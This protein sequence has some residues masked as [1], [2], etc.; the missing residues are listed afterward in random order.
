MIRT[1]YNL[2]FL[3]SFILF[4]CLISIQHGSWA[5][6]ASL[7]F[8]SLYALLIALT[9]IAV[10]CYGR[11]KQYKRL[12]FF[13][14]ILYIFALPVSL[15]TLNLLLFQ[16]LAMGSFGLW[17]VFLV[18]FNSLFSDMAKGSKKTLVM[19]VIWATLTFLV[20]Y[21]IYKNFI[22]TKALVTKEMQ[23]KYGN[24]KTESFSGC[25]NN[26]CR[27]IKLNFIDSPNY[28]ITI[29]SPDLGKYLESLRSNL[30]EVQFDVDYFYGRPYSH[31]EFKIGT[32]NK[33]TSYWGSGGCV[34]DCDSY[35]DPF[36]K[37]K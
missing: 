26:N 1:V 35:P 20:G 14:S 24:R 25:E 18:L 12:L 28:E 2:I 29:I 4:L 33:W 21:A 8:L 34:G 10:G 37:P 19:A 5:L 16:A 22:Y 31:S 13:G 15:L 7:I 23:W 9:W 3:T 17:I 11:L 6:Y 27:E 30:V 36:V 32:L